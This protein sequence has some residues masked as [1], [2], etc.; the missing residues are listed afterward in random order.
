MFPPEGHGAL[1]LSAWVYLDGAYRECVID[2][3]D[4]DNQTV[5]VCRRGT[6]LNIR[7]P[8]CHIANVTE[9][10]QDGTVIKS[11]G[12]P[13]VRAMAELFANQYEASHV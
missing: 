12:R 10:W 6:L 9:G 13:I 7:V 4:R 8:F 1:I 5:V 3:V 2:E 11:Y